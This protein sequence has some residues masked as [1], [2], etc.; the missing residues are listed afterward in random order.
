MNNKS[1]VQEERQGPLDTGLACLVMVARMHHI[2]LDAD[3]L[4][5]EY[6]HS[7]KPCDDATLLLA[8][9]RNTL[10]ASRVSSQWDR[11]AHA[12]LPV[13]ARDQEGGYFIIARADDTQALIHDPR[14]Q[15][16]EIVDRT[17]LESLWTGE[18]IFIA[19]R[20]SLSGNLA[21][22][23]FSWFV[24]AIVKYRHVLGEVMLASFI[25][26]LLALCSPLFFQVIVDKVLVHKGY[27]TLDVVAFG[28][29]VVSIFEVLLGFLRNHLFAHTSNR[30]DVE[31]GAKL[32]RHLLHL[33]QSYFGARRVGDSVA[34]VRELEN[35]RS[36]LTSSAMTV[37]LDVFF[38]VVFLAV[39]AYYSL[40]LTA[41]VV[42]TLP[43]YA[44]LSALVTPVLRNRLNDKFARGAENQAF[45]VE[46]VNGME[47]IKSLAAELQAARTWDNQLSAY[48]SASFRAAHIANFSS[49]TAGLINKLGTVAVLWLGAHFVI[50]GD[51]S[52]GQLIAF[53]MLAGRVSAPILRMV[54]LWQDFQQS[55]VSV[56]RLGDILNTPT[57][58]AENASRAALPSLQG[59]LQFEE[60]VFRYQPQ[61]RPVLQSL[62]VT[63]QPGE[64]VGIIGRSGSGK[65]TLAK[66]LQRLYV[67]EA[68]RVAVDGVDLALINPAWLRR[69]IGVVPQESMLFNRSIRENIAFNDPGAPLEL[70]I[71][72]AQMAGAHEFIVQLPQGYDS[73]VGEHGSNLSGGQRQRL[74][75]ARA[76]INNPRVLIFDE[77]TSALD[78]ESESVI[79]QNMASISAGRTVLIIAHRLSALRTAKRILVVD[80][81]R[82]T[83]D[84]RPRDLLRNP[85][86]F[87]TRLYHQQTILPVGENLEEVSA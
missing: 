13:I 16:P 18:L 2:V 9:K 7:G 44:L 53:N 33:P 87:Y 15:R 60:V 34:R 6:T 64:V 10:K 32:F 67:P 8:A 28:F 75:I 3:Q 1:P 58:Q 85:D 29:V 23:D 37:V 69:Q 22:F 21:R 70:V 83:E 26:Q 20:A 77:A 72:A 76:L 55:G 78:I 27:S 42:L 17:T 86:S 19:S 84:G 5:H 14:K 4:A 43:C 51:I 49:Q 35:I 73:V 62:S 31:L 41:V 59:R 30:I 11:L 65:S 36:F 63:I 45:L 50:Q 66:L 81:G 12:P 46:T 61:T 47:T 57:E 71:R 68:G 80:Q 39:M 38:S 25:L 24:P 52:V 79:Q 82:I 54:Q 48:V 74:A 56:R 40:W